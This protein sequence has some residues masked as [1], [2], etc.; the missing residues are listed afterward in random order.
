MPDRDPTPD[1]ARLGALRCSNYFSASVSHLIIWYQRGRALAST[2]Y[3]IERQLARSMGATANAL[4]V[5]LKLI[6]LREP[7]EFDMVNHIA[8]DQPT[9]AR[10]GVIN[11]QL[12]AF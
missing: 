2:Q 9:G 6:E 4:R 3:S 12:R 11:A 7:G 10:A 1:I 8:I 5:E